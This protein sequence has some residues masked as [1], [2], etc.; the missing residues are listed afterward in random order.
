[1]AIDRFNQTD[2]AGMIWDAIE[3]RLAERRTAA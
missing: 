3:A 1:V 2:T